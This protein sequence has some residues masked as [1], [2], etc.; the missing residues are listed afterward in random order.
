MT[1]SLSPDLPSNFVKPLSVLFGFRWFDERHWMGRDS[2]AGR[3]SARRPA[4]T[5]AIELS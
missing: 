4:S 3:L 2:V 1:A 5:F